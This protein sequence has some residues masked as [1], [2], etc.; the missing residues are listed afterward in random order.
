MAM[1]KTRPAEVSDIGVR[2]IYH[3]TDHHVGGVIGR[4]T[5]MDDK[6]MS[7]DQCLIKHVK[8]A[9]YPSQ[10]IGSEIYRK[11][12]VVEEKLVVNKL[13]EVTEG[14]LRYTKM[15]EVEVED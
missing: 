2:Q 3:V 5:I 11:Y 6:S 15:I 13:I 4:V 8:R 14:R 7:C 1:N 12:F 10:N 9:T